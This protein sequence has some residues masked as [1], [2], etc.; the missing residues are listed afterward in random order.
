MSDGSG[1]VIDVRPDDRIEPKDAGVVRGDQGR[2]E[3][4]GWGFRRV[5]ARTRCGS[6]NVA[7]LARHR[8]RRL[9]QPGPRGP[10]LEAFAAAAPD[11]G[12][13]LVGDPLAVLRP[14]SI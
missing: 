6:A 13:A 14:C 5:G 12:A 7:W 11:G 2:V 3:L 8:H 10:L 1:V 9:T 4:A